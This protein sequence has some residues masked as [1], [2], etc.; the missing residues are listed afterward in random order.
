MQALAQLDPPANV[1]PFTASQRLPFLIRMARSEREL[2]RAVEIRHAAYARHV[3]RSRT[4]AEALVERWALAVTLDAPVDW[5]RDSLV[6]EL[7]TSREVREARLRAEGISKGVV[8]P[9]H[10]GQEELNQTIR[11]A[12]DRSGIE[13]ERMYDIT[14]SVSPG[15]PVRIDVAARRDRGPAEPHARPA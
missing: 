1:V 5:H 8:K 13:N 14:T 6:T 9:S 10:Q 7:A 2:G 12:L 15:P 3:L 4:L 11:A